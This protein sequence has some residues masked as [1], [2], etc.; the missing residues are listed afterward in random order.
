MTCNVYVNG[1]LSTPRN[2][3]LRDPFNAANV[4]KLCGCPFGLNH[5]GH[6]TVAFRCCPPHLALVEALDSG[7]VPVIAAYL[8][9]NRAASPST[10]AAAAPAAMMAP[11]GWLATPPVDFADEGEPEGAVL[12]PEE[13]ELE[14]EDA[15]LEPPEVEVEFFEAELVIMLELMLVLIPMLELML[16]LD[17][18]P[19]VL[20]GVAAASMAFSYPAISAITS[21]CTAPV[22]PAAAIQDGVA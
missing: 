14:P 12:E 16:M 6:E 3:G 8:A 9:Y 19:L 10:P 11:V 1:Q 5:T 2:I 15:E 20:T 18:T 7:F 4:S 13:A 17:V 21:E 22:E